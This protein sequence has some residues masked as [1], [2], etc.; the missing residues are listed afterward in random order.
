M[1][2][3]SLS[4]AQQSDFKNPLTAEEWLF[5]QIAS[6]YI[7]QH[8]NKDGPTILQR[9]QAFCTIPTHKRYIHAVL[10]QKLILRSGVVERGYNNDE[11]ES[12]FDHAFNMRYMDMQLLQRPEI[13][14]TVYRQ[15]HDPIKERSIILQLNGCHDCPETGMFDFSKTENA[16][17]PKGMKAELENLFI[18]IIFQDNPE[19]QKR[20]MKYEDKNSTIDRFV[21]V[22][23]A[24]ES[25]IDAI[26]M[27]MSTEHFEEFFA[28]AS[29]VTEEFATSKMKMIFANKM[30]A[31][32]R[33]YYYHGDHSN[34]QHLT[35]RPRRKAIIDS[36][37]TAMYD[38]HTPKLAP[39]V[40]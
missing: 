3:T 24:M 34:H 21:K 11:T 26:A 9:F 2:S 39:K 18:K 17:L 15:G 8:L 33:D 30:L 7:E 27:N 36:V 35:G 13:A 6:E 37:I 40:A 20:M 29:E 5:V 19:M 22:T 23:D 10:G 28:T 25:A 12:I 31:S 16:I 38:D 14:N 1:S 4:F 32:I